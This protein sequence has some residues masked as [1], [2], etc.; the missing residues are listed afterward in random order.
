MTRI[1]ARGYAEKL[2]RDNNVAPGG[3]ES[4]TLG[5]FR[6]CENL[7]HTLTS[8]TGKAGFYALLSRALTLSR[9]EAPS[10]HL[11]RITHDGALELCEPDTGT[12]E[13]T[14]GI[15]LLGFMIE[16]LFIFVGNALTLRLLYE[17]WPNEL[18][19]TSEVEQD[20]SRNQTQRDELQGSLKL[21]HIS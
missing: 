4:D 20:A 10:L 13:A 14:D 11:L 15:V 19:N 9:R 16:L 3:S 7:R 18:F 2:V 21:D 8:L 17:V 12:I 1:E 5:V 6:F